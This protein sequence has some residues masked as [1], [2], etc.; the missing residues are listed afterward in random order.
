[1]SQE[2]KVPAGVPFQND[3]PVSIFNV[4]THWVPGPTVPVVPPA[5]SILLSA[6]KAVSTVM[7]SW[8]SPDF[9]GWWVR[10]GGTASP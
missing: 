8:E 1:M 3:Q 6:R 10:Q 9:G 5:G 2:N 4:M 7:T